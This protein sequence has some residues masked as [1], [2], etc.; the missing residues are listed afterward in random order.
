[1]N[2]EVNN[3]INVLAAGRRVGRSAATLR[4]WDEAGLFAVRRDRNGYR[5]YSETDLTEL[6]A[7]AASKKRG[8]PRKNRET[9]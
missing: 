1:M 5:V 7:I 2:K 8:R 6:R 9:R 4:R 3:T